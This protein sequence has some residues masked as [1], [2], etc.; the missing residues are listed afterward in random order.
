MTRRFG[1]VATLLLLVTATLG[2]LAPAQAQSSGDATATIPVTP[3]VRSVTVSPNAVT[4]GNCT[5]GGA[6]L[7]FPNDTCTTPAVTVTN[8]GSAGHINVHGSDAVP[9]DSGT[10]WSLLGGTTTSPPGPDKFA[11]LTANTAGGP[12]TTLSNTDACDE[13]FTMGCTASANQSA[14]ETVGLTGPSSSS[15]SSSSFSTTITWTAVP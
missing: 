8:T 6:S 3:L 1:G 15:D 7:T 14:N 11:E 12:G 5:K 4:Y 10:H 9:S 2:G 13:T